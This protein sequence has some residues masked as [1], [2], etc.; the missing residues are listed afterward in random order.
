MNSKKSEVKRLFISKNLNAQDELFVWCIQNQ[1]QL[2]AISQIVFNNTEFDLKESCDIVFFSSERAAQYFFQG[3]NQIESSWKYACIGEVTA[4][5]LE[6]YNVACEFIGE[7]AGNPEK[8]ACDFKEWVGGRKVCFPRSNLSL[9]SMQNVLNQAQI[10]DLEVYKTIPSAS[11]IAPQDVYVFTSPSNVNAFLQMNQIPPKAQ[12]I[13]WGRSTE[14]SL[15]LN[16]I[17]VH[18]TLQYATQKEL[19]DV[20]GAFL[21]G[22]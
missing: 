3:L 11:I 2:T 20:L 13:A 16:K 10:I 22:Q 5:K 9:K 15:L 21:Y 19:T 8:V 18:K 14:K 12:I 1:V 7:E 4:T 17:A 6:K